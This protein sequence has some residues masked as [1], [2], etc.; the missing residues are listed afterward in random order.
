MPSPPGIADSTLTETCLSYLNSQQVKALQTI[1]SDPQRAPF[2][3]LQPTL[4]LGLQH[5]RIFFS[6]LG[7]HT[8]RDLS[9]STPE[10]FDDCNNR[11]STNL[12]KAQKSSVYYIHLN[13]LSLLNGLR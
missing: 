2:I 13:K 8:K 7:I 9:D 6:V 11:A 1:T 10:L 12:L 5:T 3:D 4:P